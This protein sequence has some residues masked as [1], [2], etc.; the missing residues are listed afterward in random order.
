MTKI[1]SEQ[2]IMM[3]KIMSTHIILLII[4]LLSVMCGSC[5]RDR[6][7]RFKELDNLVPETRISNLEQ[8]RKKGILRVVTEFNSISYFIY[9]GQPMGFQYEMLQDLD[10]LH[11]PAIG[12]Y[13][14]Q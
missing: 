4:T 3:K 2:F 6:E 8:I 14:Q 13:S 7:S 9:R 10:K 12:G 11:G 5:N 1:Y